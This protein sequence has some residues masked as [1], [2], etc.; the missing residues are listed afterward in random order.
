MIMKSEDFSLDQSKFSNKEFLVLFTNDFS[1]HR[2]DWLS[3]LAQLASDQNRFL[4]IAAIDTSRLSSTLIPANVTIIQFISKKE[5]V[6]FLNFK[7]KGSPVVTWDGDQWLLSSLFIRRKTKMLIM[8]PYLSIFSIKGILIFCL[9]RVMI[10][11]LKFLNRSNFA[12]LSIPFSTRKSVFAEWVD[13]ELLISKDELCA[14]RKRRQ[15]S[16]NKA[17]FDI[18]LPGYISK[19]KNAQILIEACR[20]LNHAIPGIF[21]LSVKGKIE[22]ES[23]KSYLL[24]NAKW[25]RIENRYF[26][27]T[28]YLNLLA[29]S[30]LVAIPY[31]NV[32]SSGVVME[33]LAIGVPVIVSEHR[34]WRNLKRHFPNQVF[35]SKLDVLNVYHSIIT[36]YQTV[37]KNNEQKYY[38]GMLRTSALKF[39]SEESK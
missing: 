35:L 24:E 22:D 17:Y 36:N 31:S 8:R 3:K 29:E 9:K 7:M 18:L 11:I 4:I 26:D 28:E 33:C 20:K 16:P 21:R 6:R 19:R 23:L 30:D 14:L 39:L 27:R 10:C 2:L 38:S 1:G 15:E 37:Q 34:L 25:L 5:I 12:F 13:D 32:A